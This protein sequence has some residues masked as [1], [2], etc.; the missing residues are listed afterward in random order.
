MFISG[1][2]SKIPTAAQQSKKKNNDASFYVQNRGI[3]L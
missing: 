1:P 3:F 2:K